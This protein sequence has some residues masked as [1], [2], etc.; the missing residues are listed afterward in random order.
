[1]APGPRTPLSGQ[2]PGPKEDDQRQTVVSP[3]PDFGLEEPTLRDALAGAN[4]QIQEAEQEEIST[5]PDFE[6]P[7]SLE[8]DTDPELCR[9]TDRAPPP[10]GFEFD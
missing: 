7:A 1:M 10:D 8:P 2:L 4:V 9:D 6:L 5:D 3:P